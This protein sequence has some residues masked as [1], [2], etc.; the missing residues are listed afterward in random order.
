MTARDETAYPI[1]SDKIVITWTRPT[2]QVQDLVPPVI[3]GRG[4]FAGF[5]GAGGQVV[6][7][8]GAARSMKYLF[9]FSITHGLP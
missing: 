3:P 1:E 5:G 6:S 8:G 7:A 2:W 4:Y 9:T